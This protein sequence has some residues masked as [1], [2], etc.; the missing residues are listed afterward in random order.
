MDSFDLVWLEF[1][2]YSV[3]QASSWVGLFV[4]SLHWNFNCNDDR[5][6]VTREICIIALAELSTQRYKSLLA[7]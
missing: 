6:Y 7:F 4:K 2:F 5:N 3:E 1:N